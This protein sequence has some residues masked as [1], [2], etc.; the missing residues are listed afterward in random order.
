[1]ADFPLIFRMYT[2]ALEITFG[3]QPLGSYGDELPPRIG[4]RFSM[5]SMGTSFP[6]TDSG[7]ASLPRT[8]QARTSYQ[9]CHSCPWTS[10][11]KGGVAGGPNFHAASEGL[12]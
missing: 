6:D 3:E 12:Q 8:F 5:H 1:M 11:A 7:L 9:R 2:N 4:E 10:T